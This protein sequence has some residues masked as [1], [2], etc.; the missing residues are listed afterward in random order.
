LARYAGSRSV[1][2]RPG[3]TQTP[4]TCCWPTPSQLVRWADNYRTGTVGGPS[5]LSANL[6]GAVDTQL[7]DGVRYG[8]GIF[9]RPDGS[10]WHNGSFT[11]FMS[12]FWVSSDR[13]TSVAPSCN[14]DT[15]GIDLD[16]MTET[17]SLIWTAQ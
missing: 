10:L 13:S 15:D 8:A 16:G 1:R 3:S 6:A 9:E 12:E 4:T 7:G 5:W 14:V 17:L 11:G 2:A